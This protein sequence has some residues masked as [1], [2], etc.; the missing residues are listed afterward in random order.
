MAFAKE[1]NQFFLSTE[2]GTRALCSKQRPGAGLKLSHKCIAPC[3]VPSKGGGDSSTTFP[4]CISKLWKRGV[5]WFIIRLFSPLWQ[6]PAKFSRTYFTFLKNPTSLF[7]HKNPNL[8]C[9][10]FYYA[11]T[12]VLTI[13][14]KHMPEFLLTLIGVK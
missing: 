2:L 7:P 5:C 8:Y 14:T 3:W 12:P 1:T 6:H 9:E 10:I 11:N 13:T 4:V